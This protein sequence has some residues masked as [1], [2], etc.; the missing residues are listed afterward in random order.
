M[1]KLLLEIYYTITL[2]N[3]AKYISG[4]D[5]GLPHCLWYEKME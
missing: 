3:M 4:D 2:K 5:N 1:K